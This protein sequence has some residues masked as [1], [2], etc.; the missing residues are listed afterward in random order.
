[1]SV[2]VPFT[3]GRG[4]TLALQGHVAILEFSRPPLNF[5]DK[6][7]IEDLVA[8]LEYLD[9][10][11]E[12]RVV[13]L[14]AAGKTFCAGADFNG[15]EETRDPQ[16]PR[17]LY[18]YAVRLFRTRKPI[19][20]VVEGAAV[21]GGLGLA[22]VG[23][24]RVTSEKARFCAN[25]NRLGIHQGFGI[26]VTLPRVVG[27]QMASLLIATGRRIDGREAVR[28]GLADVLAEPGCE[29]EAALALAWEI[30]QSSPLAVMS[31]R[32][33]LRAGL[34]DAVD[35][36]IDREA[37]EQEWQ[38][39]SADFAEGNRAMAERRTPVFTGK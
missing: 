35:A 13:L 6:E 38:I 34:A 20:V 30:A 8:A 7:L 4:L 36:V 15:A 28:I 16:F 9:G 39:V 11:A 14:Q 33:T 12:C 17:R 37:S 21:G 29:R 27:I 22:L 1:M 5:F 23:D 19:I 26:S 32:E 18:K 24:Y 10:A 2:A 31:S 25:F 3:P